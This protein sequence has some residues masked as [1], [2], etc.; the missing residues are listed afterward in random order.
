MKNK[1]HEGKGKRKRQF[2]NKRKGEQNIIFE[3]EKLNKMF[4]P[5]MFKHI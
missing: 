3:T 1:E 4:F 2:K 5:F